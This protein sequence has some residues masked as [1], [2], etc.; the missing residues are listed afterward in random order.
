MTIEQIKKEYKQEIKQEQKVY[1]NQKTKQKM[2]E[3]MKEI[4][5]R[6]VIDNKVKEMYNA[7]K[8]DIDAEL[9]DRM[10]YKDFEEF[11]Y[12]ADQIIK[13]GRYKEIMKKI[14]ERFPELAKLLSTKGNMILNY[15]IVKY[16]LPYLFAGGMS[17]K[18][19]IE[20]IEKLLDRMIIY[21]NF[22]Q[23]FKKFEEFLKKYSTP[24]GEAARIF[25]SS[26]MW[27]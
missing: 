22:K 16:V 18:K 14:E 21:P 15:Y 13:D 12:E 11:R 24:D 8:Y 23:F 25:I 26:E 19:I 4:E 3:L 1:I 27:K 20:L 10:G 7:S 2:N 9:K 17:K 5:R 6:Q